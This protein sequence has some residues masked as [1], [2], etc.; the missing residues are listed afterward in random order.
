MELNLK[1]NDITPL[2]NIS[3]SYSH[4]GQD[5]IFSHLVYTDAIRV[6]PDSMVRFDG[7]TILVVVKG[8]LNVVINS[9]NYSVESGSVAVLTPKDLLD[10]SVSPGE[11]ADVYTLFLSRDFI[12]GINIDIGIIKPRRFMGQSPVM[13]LDD[14]QL[15]LV[16][17]YL[18]LLHD[19]T[20]VNTAG[21]NQLGVITRSIGRSLIVTLL[22][23]LAYISEKE[24]I[25]DSMSINVPV[26]RSRKMNYVHQFLNVL[27]QYFRRERNVAFYA[28][29]LCISP[30]YLS[31]LV[32]E[33]TGLSAAAIIDQYVITEAK[34]MLRFSGDTIQQVAYKLNFPNQSAFG[35]YFKHMT[36]QSPTAFRCS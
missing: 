19:C 20:Q 3:E 30:K 17:G 4:A 28:D 12:K 25:A 26:A 29:K 33:A 22:Y 13:A 9:T 2:S 21:P 7:V 5:Y 10:H 32:R 14:D 27:E 6:E 15:R 24:Q 36:G 8:N 23:Q 34:N 31:L 16:V 35:K 18:N 11:T 1:L